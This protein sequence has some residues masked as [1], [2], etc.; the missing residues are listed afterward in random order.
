MIPTKELEEIRDHLNEQIEK[1]EMKNVYFGST[2]SGAVH[3]T[4][5]GKKTL[6][7]QQRIKKYDGLNTEFEW[8]E[9]DSKVDCLKCMFNKRHDYTIKRMQKY[10]LTQVRD[11]LKEKYFKQVK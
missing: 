4:I 10:A 2:P 7:G 9:T 6:C 3:I 1:I 8:T 11:W 5:D